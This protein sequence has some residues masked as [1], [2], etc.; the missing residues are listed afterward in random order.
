[1]EMHNHHVRDMLIKMLE[2][3]VGVNHNFSVSAGKSGK[4]F[5]NLLPK[6][7]YERFKKT[8]SDAD[9]EHMWEAAFEM[10]YLFGDAARSVASRLSF[11][12]DEEEEQGIEF[13]MKK[14]REE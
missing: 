10:L 9:R 2:W 12:Y 14:V 6:D 8:Y 1:M 3:Y 7:T 11:S 5:K 4:Y 13:Y